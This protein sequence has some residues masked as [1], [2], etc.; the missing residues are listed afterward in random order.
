V[1]DEFPMLKIALTGGIGS[2]KTTVTDYFR[3]LGV[4]VIDADETSHEVTQAGEPAV[5]K[6]SD[7][8]GDSVLDCDGNL[9]RTAL[10]NIVFGD[11]E[12][13]K[14]LES[15]LHPEIRRRMNETASR[16]QSPYCLFSIPLLIETDQHTSYDRIL[17]V[18][19]SEDRRRSWIQAR[20]DLTQNEITAILSAQVSDEQR[21]HAADDL[22]MNDGGIDDLH[23]RIERLHQT[24]LALSTAQKQP[25]G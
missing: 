23:A 16:T 14:L 6:I 11:P 22:L 13:R 5:Q 8:F 9:D 4:P 21:R 10:R 20:S 18:E 17:V 25:K 15:I 24:Y 12:S 19:A 7:A 1:W 3:K 2:G